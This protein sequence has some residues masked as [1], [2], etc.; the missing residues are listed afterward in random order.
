[1]S[2]EPLA[3]PRE[4][5]PDERGLCPD[6]CAMDILVAHNFYQQPGGEDQ[7]VAAEVAVMKAHGHNVIQYCVH[8]NSID[9]MHRFDAALR[10]MWNG[11]TYHELR[12]LF[13][14]HR[15]Q[16]AHFHNTFPLISPA[17]YYAARAENIPVVQTVHNF[18][19][20]C[21]NALLFRDGEVCEDCVGK[22]VTWPGVVHKCYRGSF[23]ATSTVAAMLA[24]HRAMG[25]WRN[26]VDAYITLTEFAQNKLI[27]GGLPAGKVVL[28][29][30][31]VHPDPGPGSGLGGYA[32]F[33]GRLSAEKGLE[34]LLDAWRRLAGKLL[35]K[36]I[37]DGP[38]AAKV[39]DATANDA[40]IQWLGAKPLEAV[41]DAV[42]HATALVLPSE[43]YE[44]FPR[45]LVEAFAKGTPV[46][47]S[48]L[49]AMATIVS[50]GRT[51]LLFKPGNSEDLAEKVECIFSDPRRL[52]RMRQAARDEFARKFTAESNHRTL[53]AIYEQ[54]VRTATK[55]SQI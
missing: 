24:V 44:N 10:T 21:P 22:S 15:P 45:V 6:F 19:L 14:T 23:A 11:R 3:S 53:M 1:M 49:G 5:D 12:E 7:A 43:C 2:D 8:N 29:S 35:L 34:T 25:T 30:N 46:I 47:A 17:G 48:D 18:R 40:S 31:F 50:N 4:F 36:I 39:K 41:Y 20:L 9:A 55:H 32:V 27:E 33:V 13:K 16:I 54:A 52:A 37:G 51:G 26:A 38:M 28:K 42:G